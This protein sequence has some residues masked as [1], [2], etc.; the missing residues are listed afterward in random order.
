VKAS[1][2]LPGKA[3]ALFMAQTS[4]RQFI[5]SLIHPDW[6]LDPN[7]RPPRE[8]IDLAFD[9]RNPARTQ[10][11]VVSIAGVSGSVRHSADGLAL[12]SV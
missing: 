9:V 7:A 4:T 12:N 3:L 2:L 11:V 1:E 5:R 8:L 6:I 10:D